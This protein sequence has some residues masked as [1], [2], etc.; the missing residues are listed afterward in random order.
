[1]ADSNRV[2]LAIEEETVYGVVPTGNPKIQNIRFKNESL[3][4]DQETVI[5]EEIRADCNI[6]DTIRVGL[7]AAGDIN[8]EYSLAAFDLYY[9]ALLSSPGWSTVVS[10]SG[11]DISFVAADNSINRVAADFITAGFLPYQWLKTIGATN[12]QNVGWAKIATVAAAK[13]TCTH[14]TFI[15]EAASAS[16]T[17]KQGVYIENG[18]EPRSFSIEK[19]FEDI[20]NTFLTYSGMV[21]NT[22]SFN[23]SK[24]AVITGSFGFIGKLENPATATFGDGSNDAAPTD[25]VADSVS[26][27]YAVFRDINGVKTEIDIVSFSMNMNANHREKEVCG[28]LGPK[29][30]GKGSFV[31]NGSLQL[32]FEDLEAI[33]DVRNYTATDIAIII[34]DVATAFIIDLPKVKFKDGPANAKGQNQDVTIDLEF[35]AVLH[36]DELCTLRM[37]SCPS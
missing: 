11:T 31:V 34:K 15:D 18:T 32:Y 23:I 26:S 27:I 6:P 14:K 3:K 13:L 1:M 36:A 10:V 29:S 33:T 28:T 22:G 30:I 20:P 16:I 19:E 8:Y 7:K 35:D 17:V 2:N 25:D 9:E 12:Y 37:A 4:L 24:K 5:S 21:F